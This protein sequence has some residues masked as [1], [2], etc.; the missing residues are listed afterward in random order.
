MNGLSF[1]SSLI[2]L[3]SSSIVRFLT[4]P[5]FLSLILNVFALT[6]FS[7]ITIIYLIHSVSASLILLPTLSFLSST[8]TRTSLLDISS[9]IE[10]P[11]KHKI[12]EPLLPHL[13]KN[14]LS[15]LFDKFF[16]QRFVFIVEI[17]CESYCHLIIRFI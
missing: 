13:N 6:S 9:V 5:V 2:S 10:L 3:T 14:W 1:V 16:D 11:F 8:S 12:E 15:N 7:P 17:F 4:L